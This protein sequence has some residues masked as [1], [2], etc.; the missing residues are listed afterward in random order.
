MNIK[1]KAGI[2]VMALG[3]IYGTLAVAMPKAA[4]G[5]PMAPKIF[6]IA[7]GIGLVILGVLYFMKESVAYKEQV[8]K[9]GIKEIDAKTA[10][11]NKKTNKLIIL[12]SIAGLGYA[13]FFEHLGYVIS[14]SLF[15][16]IIMFA[17]NGK[18]NWK[19]NI[20]VALVFSVTVY[21]LFFYV[22]AIPLPMMPI[23]EI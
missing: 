3:A 21:I 13:F 9:E 19:L 7:L 20:S 12:T 15:I 22:L 6:P 1:M 8:K 10:E 16:G 11:L 5:N 14:T 23:L 2:G 4:I 18:K 17:I